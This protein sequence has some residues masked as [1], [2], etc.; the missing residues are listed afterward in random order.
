MMNEALRRELE[1]EKAALEARRQ[2]LEQLIAGLEAD[3]EAVSFR[4]GHVNA[5]IREPAME[6]AAEDEQ[7]DTQRVEESGD[8]ADPL[9]IAY[10]I[11]EKRGAEPVY[12]REL[13]EM[14]R[15]KGGDLEGSDPAMTL[16]SKLVTDDRFVRPF[17]R[18]WYALRAYYPKTRSVGRRK[19]RSSKRS[20][21][22]IGS[23]LHEGPNNTSGMPR[24]S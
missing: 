17:R 1:R 5:L 2:E 21:P 20:R 14:V 8:A 3:K 22:R 11:L 6:A 10:G 18:G 23:M 4:L 24:P 19:K 16:V 9:E 13:A 7:A 15:Q 12:Y